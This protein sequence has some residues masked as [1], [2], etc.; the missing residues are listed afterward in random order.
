M[1]CFCCGTC[2]SKYQPRLSLA[3]A[4]LLTQ[5]LGLS[6]ECFLSEYADSRWPGTA[7]YLLRHRNGA[8]LFLS[9]SPDSKQNLCLIHAFKPEC[10]RD[11]AA[12]PEKPECRQGLKKNW[13]LTLEP[14]GK[15][16]GDPD[17]MEAFERYRESLGE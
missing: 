15:I 16:S 5:K 14:D 17:K 6:W 4:R 2:C 12:G 1:R 7:S 3:E 10:C 13:Q 8:C 9:R 11:W